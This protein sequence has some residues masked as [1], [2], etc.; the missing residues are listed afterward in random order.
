[1]HENAYGRERIT[2]TQCNN[3]YVLAICML[4]H[5]IRI[6]LFRVY[7]QQNTHYVRL[8]AKVMLPRSA[9]VACFFFF[10]CTCGERASAIARRNVAC[11]DRTTNEYN[12]YFSLLLVARVARLRKLLYL[13]S[14]VIT[15]AASRA[16]FKIYLV[17]R[18]AINSFA[19][20]VQAN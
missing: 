12:F 20:S 10:L 19:R 13:H 4:V 3:L 17:H 6:H 7:I 5:N 8:C 18:A 1:M 9:A 2:K 11:L 15:L 16:K 14:F